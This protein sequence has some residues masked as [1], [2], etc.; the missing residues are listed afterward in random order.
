MNGFLSDI[1][2]ESIDEN[3]EVERL[4]IKYMSSS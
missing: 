3:M 1:I 2:L 4:I